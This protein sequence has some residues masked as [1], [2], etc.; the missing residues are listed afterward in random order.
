MLLLLLMM[1][2]RAVSEKSRLMKAEFPT[3]THK[4]RSSDSAH[5]F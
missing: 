1:P 5:S 2:T 4:R 3:R